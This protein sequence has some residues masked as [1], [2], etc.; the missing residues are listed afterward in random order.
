MLVGEGGGRGEWTGLQME[1]Y[2]M[3]I[4]RECGGSWG[5]LMTFMMNKELEE[6]LFRRNW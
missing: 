4:L 5:D 6:R 1:G 3:V 2:G